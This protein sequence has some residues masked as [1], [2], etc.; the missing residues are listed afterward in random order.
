MT[1]NLKAVVTQTKTILSTEVSEALKQA[2]E[3]VYNSDQAVG[4]SKR[5]NKNAAALLLKK[6][7]VHSDRLSSSSY[8]KKIQTIRSGLR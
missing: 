8:L 5:A 6:E 3:A 2:G 4:L 7:K 1:S